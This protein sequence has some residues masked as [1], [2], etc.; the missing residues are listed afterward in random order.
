MEQTVVE[1]IIVDLDNECKAR[2]MFVN[3]DMYLAKEKE[4]IINS[5]GVGC[6]V[7]SKRLI[8]YH[9]MAEQYYNETYNK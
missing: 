7:E 2:G 5:F 9:G 3:W 6:Q 8:G 1:S 4:Q